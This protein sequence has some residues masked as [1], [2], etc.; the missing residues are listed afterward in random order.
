MLRGHPGRLKPAA[1]LEWRGA[2]LSLEQAVHG[3]GG[4]EAARRGDLLHRL[5]RA[6]E[7]RPRRFEPLV[8]HVGGRGLTGVSEEDAREVALAESRFPCQGGNGQIVPQVLPNPADEVRDRIALGHLRGEGCAE[9]ALASG[10]SQVHDQ[11]SRDFECERPAEVFLEES[12]GEIHAGRNPGGGPDAPVA[13]EDSVRIDVALGVVFGEC[14]ARRPMG[15]CSSLIEQ[16]RFGQQKCAGANGHDSSRAGSEST[17]VWDDERP[18]TAHTDSAWDQERVDGPTDRADRSRSDE[19]DP[20]RG[21]NRPGTHGRQLNVIAALCP[22]PRRG[23]EHVGRARDVEELE[24]IEAQ[25]HHPSRSLNPRI[26]WNGRIRHIFVI[27]PYA[28]FRYRRRIREY[29]MQIAILIYPGLTALDAIGPYEVFNALPDRELRFV[30]KEVG[31]VVTDSGALAIGCTHTFEE[32]PSPDLVLVPGSSAD[33]AT[34]M[35]D[36]EVL[37]WLRAVH[38][39]TRYTTS[40]CS[41]AMILA[42][43]GILDGL[44]ATTH[45]LAMPGLKNFGATPCP[46]ERVVKEGKIFTAAGVSA[47]IDLALTMVSEMEGPERAQMIQ[48][49][50]EYDPQPPFDSGHLSKADPAIA[51]SARKEMIKAALNPR[52]VVSIPT[53]LARRWREVLVRRVRRRPVGSKSERPS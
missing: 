36:K 7:G 29:A 25:D 42:A 10:A 16:A 30:W 49:A 39:R 14:V 13:H 32:T 28:F 4:R 52:D 45:W 27:P 22:E 8:L 53:V 26:P 1:V 37:S 35:A 31:P 21:P 18:R 23:G 33:T 34:M 2:D 19:F 15:G 24:V 43:A 46:N 12:E 38:T 47:G 5:C 41:G 44:R 3:F 11:P 48:L 40:V 9:L 17:D 20:P 51:A 50:I 6:F